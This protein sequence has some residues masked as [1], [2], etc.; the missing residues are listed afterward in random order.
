MIALLTYGSL[1]HPDELAT[2]FG[3]GTRCLPVRVRGFRRSF[4]QKPAW[5]SGED[6]RNGVLTVRRS[7][8]AWFNGILVGPPDPRSLERLDHR[9]RGYTRR[10]VPA[11]AVEPYLAAPSVPAIGEYHL[12]TGRD[13][14]RSDGLAPN[15]EYL[16]LCTEAARAR[17]RRF[18]EEFL[19]TTYVDR[20]SLR[21]ILPRPA[22]ID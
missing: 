13:E 4:C 18:L 15:P 1:M 9:E 11:V 7:S 22:T 17:G 12:Y 2:Q 21:E 8:T 5:R 19:S 14:M 16:R 6:G 20:T 3:G 10:R